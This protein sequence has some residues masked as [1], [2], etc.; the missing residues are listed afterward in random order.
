[1]S[2]RT[3]ISDVAAQ[4]GVSI[5]TVSL[6]MN[7]KGSVADGT[8]DHVRSVAE[9]LGY[10]PSRSA[11]RLAGGRTGNV[12]FVLRED[13]FRHSE[14]FYTR[15]FLGAEFEARRRGLYVLLTTIPG[16]FR[17]ADT[18]RFLKENSVDGVVV[19]GSV[20]DAFLRV[21]DRSGVPY[22]LA[23]YAW[24]GASAVELDNHGGATR[25]AEH[26]V[27]Q[28]HTRFGFLGA[29]PGHPSLVARRAGFEAGVA[30][31]G[32]AVHVVAGEA[33]ATRRAGLDLAPRLLDADARPTAVFCAN[34]ALAL[35]LLDA[36]Q[37]RG[38]R[39]P[40]DLAV[41]GFDD[42]D[43][44]ALAAPPLTTVRVYK[45]QLGET[46]LAQ[47]CERVEAGARTDRAPTTTRIATELVVR[48]S[49]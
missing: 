14:P 46:A 3:T 37:A 32:F 21:L 9:R 7:E 2:A 22:V 13:H 1:M 36:A 6:V 35:G 19:A 11:R 34:D 16:T 33:G 48:Q 44:A 39:V 25:V 31:A 17:A 23:D 8:R 26:L 24:R 42:V 18:P 28:G 38:L 45:E 49:G 30:E 40:D 27:A 41:V 4:A 15:V 20:D 12:G 5:S 43:A 10:T 47:L 29:D